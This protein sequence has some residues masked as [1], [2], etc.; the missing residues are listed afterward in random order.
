MLK[1]L[2]AVL[3]LAAALCAPAQ[4]KV[5]EISYLKNGVY[6][7]KMAT[8]SLS[9][10]TYLDAAQAARAIGGKIYWYPVSGKLLLQIRGNKVVFFM[11]SDSVLINDDK[12]AFPNPMIVRGGKAFLALDFFVS[13]HFAR[14]FGFRLDYNPATAALAAQRDINI[15]SVNYF[16]YQDKTRIV[17]YMEEPLEW[18]SSQKEN[19]LVSLTI[20]GG[21]LAGEEKIAIGDGVVRGVDLV[22]EN[23]MARLVINP[24]ANFGKVDA[25][26]LSD[27]DR[28]VV[29]IMKRQEVISQGIS[30]APADEPA[31]IAPSGG[32][33]GV[34]AATAAARAASYAA[35]NIPDKLVVEKSG[36]KR[37]VID[38]GHGG[39]D[40][41]GKK[42]FGL[43]EKEMNLL[44][45]KELYGLLKED[46]MFEVLLT[47]SNDEFVPLS[48]RSG[49]ANTYKAD[50]F[51]SIHGNASRD[52]KEKGFEVYFMSEKASDPGA[53]EVADYENSVLG[54][55]GGDKQSDAAAMLL[56]S[57]ARNEYVNEGSRLAGLVSAEMEKKTPFAN[58]G[59]K[60]AAF[61]VLRGTYSPGI[62]V[63]MGFMSNSTDQKNLNDK[64]VRTKIANAIHRG[65]LAYAKMKQ[66]Q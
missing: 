44:V 33:F 39:K 25:F 4:A 59:V 56:H 54:L 52:R 53:A 43:K 18:R 24:D 5:A 12:T 13:K 31:V 6:S 66:W 32:G 9:G 30:G 3:F 29:D 37:I 62:L 46:D 19:N 36:R 11:K 64:K 15:T 41:G 27:P 49:I 26:R 51:V 20:S 48:E 42:L 47:R 8:Y 55:E 28:I 7:G 63:E 50:L 14:A 21:V 38:A 35:V 45:A 1:R 60:Q 2:S 16:S 61:Y 40:A 10:S 65:I 34:S 23:K 57:M 22:Q 17:I 58:R